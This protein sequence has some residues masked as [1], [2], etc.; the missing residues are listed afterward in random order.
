MTSSELTKAKNFLKA[1]EIVSITAHIKGCNSFADFNK[2]N[3]NLNQIEYLKSVELSNEEIN[4]YIDS[5]KGYE[6]LYN[7]HKNLTKEY[8]VTKLEAIKC[9]LQEH[10]QKRLNNE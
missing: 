2:V 8:I 7:K 1:T 9:K 6:Y 3:D 4:F 5:D 10:D